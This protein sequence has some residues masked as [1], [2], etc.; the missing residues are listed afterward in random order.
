MLKSSLRTWGQSSIPQAPSAVAVVILQV[1]HLLP[2]CR[3]GGCRGGRAGSCSGH[4]EPNPGLSDFSV[5]LLGPV[6]FLHSF[7]PSTQTNVFNFKSVFKLHSGCK[8]MCLY[9]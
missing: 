8:K 2:P 6:M 9:I 3:W 7:I 5:P 4:G 1:R